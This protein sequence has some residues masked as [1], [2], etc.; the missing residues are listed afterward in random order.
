M[1]AVQVIFGGIIRTD[2]QIEGYL[3]TLNVATK[4]KDMQRSDLHRFA[5]KFPYADEIK[6]SDVADW[7]EGDLMGTG[8]LSAPTCR[9]IISACRCYW[10][11]M[12]KHHRLKAPPP[13][14]GV[15]PAQ[16]KAAHSAHKSKRK[17]FSRGDYTK[18][19]KASEKGPQ[20][21]SD[22]IVLAT[23]TGARIEELCSLKIEKVS[24]DRIEIEDAKTVAGWRTV[25]IH[26]HIAKLVKSLKAE[27][28]EGYLISGLTFNK[29]GDRSNAIGKRFG[30][31]K[32]KLGYGPDFVFHSFRK[33]GFATQL[34]SAKVPENIAARLL[35]HEFKTMSYG[36]YS[37][38][39]DFEVLKEALG[40]I[41]WERP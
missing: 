30:R 11:Y 9:R 25:P 26:P 35:G 12:E 32:N 39:V 1:E 24:E 7:V 16:R 8:H 15:V 3:E 13:F 28:K 34:E 19:L 10:R 21:L 22:L 14:E 20:E 17:A 29:Y 6:Q 27:S 2:R 37:G 33:K 38:G 41:D 40:N 31:L 18:L 23:Y 5:K 4:T 36:V